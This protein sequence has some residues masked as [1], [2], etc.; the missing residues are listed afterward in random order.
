MTIYSNEDSNDI[1]RNYQPYKKKFDS[2]LYVISCIFSPFGQ[3]IRT[4]L[5]QEYIERLEKLKKLLQRAEL[6]A[7]SSPLGQCCLKR[8]LV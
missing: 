5:A 6:L 3:D 4:K 2:M 1:Q 8:T 7:P